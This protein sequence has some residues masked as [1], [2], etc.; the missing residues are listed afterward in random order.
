MSYA[1]RALERVASRLFPV[2]YY[3]L[4]SAVVIALVLYAGLS[5]MIGTTGAGS[6]DFRLFG[7]AFAVITIAWTLGLVAV[8]FE[9]QRGSF[10]HRDTDRG[11]VALWRRAQ[12]L[13][14]GTVLLAC[15]GGTI[16]FLWFGFTA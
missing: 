8:W 15:V 9:P 6:S 13:L 7:V 16:V 2:R 10:R 14:A 4:G 5:L 1:R 11:A 3:L 12:R